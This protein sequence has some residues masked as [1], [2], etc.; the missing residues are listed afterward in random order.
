MHSLKTL[1]KTIHK[2]DTI[3]R[4][5]S[6]RRSTMDD[7]QSLWLYLQGK[8]KDSLSKVSYDTWILSANPINL[9]DKTVVIEVPSPL[10]KE[11]WENN[12][13]TRTV[14]FVYE[15]FGKEV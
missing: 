9:T 5:H 14:E 3:K 15:Y 4:N 6:Q 8:F 2:H 7:L 11:Y 10:H 12:L 1:W 13:T